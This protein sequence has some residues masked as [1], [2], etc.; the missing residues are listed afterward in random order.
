M[1]TRIL[2]LVALW[3]L[4]SLGTG[5]LSAPAA[6]A[7]SGK[8][9]VAASLPDLAAIAAA[10]GG[11][12]VQVTA[13]SSDLQ[14][15]HFVDAKPSLLLT[16]RSADVLLVNGM[17][18][19]VGWLPPM[20]V[21][22]RNRRIGQGSA[23]YVD[24]STVITKRDV[25][26]ADRSKGDIHPGGN[27][28]FVHDPNAALAI[29]GLL[30]KR[31]TKLDG[32]NAKHYKARAARFAKKLRYVMAVEAKRFAALPTSKRRVVT[33]HKSLGYLAAWLGLEVV[34][35]VEAKPGV[36]PTPSQVG[37]VLKT[38]RRTGTRVVVQ[39]SFYPRKT[40]QTLARLAGGRAALVPGGTRFRLGETY[41]LRVR[42]TASEIYNALTK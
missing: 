6:Q 1:N 37:A 40:A 11:D 34:A 21:N 12:K 38:M 3:T 24:A 31:F 5:L 42:R 29:A 16:L 23:G 22:S 13:L 27:P 15:P 20:I 35:H 17:E 9:K 19:E 8:L 25:Q 2:T 32:A 26:K 33:Y 14:D 36:S 39:E 30:A 7:S 4:G 28:H 41:I 10:V 18:L